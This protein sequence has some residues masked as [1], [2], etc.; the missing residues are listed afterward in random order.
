M[1]RIR[2]FLEKKVKEMKTG[3]APKASA[4]ITDAQAAAESAFSGKNET[5]AQRKAR[6]GRG[7]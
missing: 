3:L 2:K 7:Q 6:L 5:A 1:A 4:A